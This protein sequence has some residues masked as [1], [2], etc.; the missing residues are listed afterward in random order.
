MNF[1]RFVV[2]N[3]WKFVSRKKCYPF[4][5]FWMIDSIF[6]SIEY[7]PNVELIRHH[8]E[9]YFEATLNMSTLGRG[10]YFRTF[11][12][13]FIFFKPMKM[14]CVHDRKTTFSMTSKSFSRTFERYCCHFFLKVDLVLAEIIKHMRNCIIYA[15]YNIVYSHMML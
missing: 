14:M 1:L 13:V 6:S 10:Y 12:T 11:G 4:I 3:N 8:D 9:N 15:A 2:A 5:F 7:F